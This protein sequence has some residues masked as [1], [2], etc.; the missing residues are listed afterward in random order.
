[1]SKFSKNQIKI[2][3]KSE[4]FYEKFGP[5]TFWQNYDIFFVKDQQQIQQFFT[6]KIRFQNG[7]KTKFVFPRF[8]IMDSKN[9]AKERIVYK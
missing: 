7:A 5:E 6:K 8:S 1:M 3:Q 2:K 4:K 9:G